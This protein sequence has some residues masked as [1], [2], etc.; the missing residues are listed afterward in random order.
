MAK[1]VTL[2]W[3]TYSF[4]TKLILWVDAEMIWCKGNYY[5]VTIHLKNHKPRKP[6]LEIKSV[7]KMQTMS[8]KVKDAATAIVAT[9]W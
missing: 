1:F 4:I 3:T 5:V 9:S 6:S 7:S 8:S 2:G